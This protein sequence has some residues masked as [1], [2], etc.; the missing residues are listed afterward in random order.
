LKKVKIDFNNMKPLKQ[1][2]AVFCISLIMILVVFMPFVIMDKGSFTY[3]GDYNCQ[4]MAFYLEANESIRNGE[5]MW[6]FNTDL[7]ANFIGSY[8]FY[9]IGSPFFWLTLLLPLNWVSASIPF[10]ICIKTAVAAT[11]SF[12]FLKRVVKNKNYAFIDCLLYAFSGFCFYNVFFN[13][14]HDIIALF[15]LMLIGVEKMLGEGKKGFMAV[16]V[17]LNAVTNYYFFVAEV[18]FT[19]IY[20]IVGLC[21]KRWE[22]LNL[23]R[24]FAFGLECIIGFLMA[25]FIVLPAVLTTLQIDRASTKL[26]GWNLL[27]YNETQ[28]PLQL[29]QG[30]FMPPEICSITNMLPE[31][32]GRW[33]SVNAYLPMFGMA[34][35]I[36][37]LGRRKKRSFFDYMVWIP[38]IMMFVPVLNSMFQLFSNNFY[39]RWLFTLV[40]M[41]SAATIKALEECTFKEWIYGIG[42][43]SAVALGLSVAIAL[44][45]DPE[46]GERGLCKET[47]LLWSQIAILVAGLILTLL[48]IYAIKTDKKHATAFATAF[49][50]AFCTLFGI[51]YIAVSKDRDT[52]DEH[53]SY[54]NKIVYGRWNMETE[55]NDGERIDTVNCQSNAP[56]YWNMP[57]PRAFHSIVPGSV[58]DFYDAIGQ[59]RDVKSD[60]DYKNYP[61]QSLLSVRYLFDGEPDNVHYGNFTYL[62]DDNGNAVY[63]YKYYIPM[64]FGYDYYITES[65]LT[66]IQENLRDDVMLAVMV[67]ADEQEELVSDTMTKSETDE[68]YKLIDLDANV[69]DRKND[70]CNEFSYGRNSFTADYDND[71]DSVVFFSIPYEAGWSA[72]VNGQ[73]AEIIKTNV[74]FMAVK[75]EAGDN[76][77]EFKYVTPGLKYGA[78]LA[79]ISL[80]G[81]IVYMCI[82]KEIK[83]KEK[84]ECYCENTT[85]V[86]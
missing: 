43:T 17:F 37:Y 26:T 32:G 14:F 51:Y 49:V 4:Q 24:F 38:V 50:M 53:D 13:H 9:L 79:G 21:T 29:I 15:P 12:G 60:F 64:G 81:L 69:S 78:I 82:G 36:T 46:T 45:K 47:S 75:T 74:G 71:S 42:K 41:M 57:S 68:V 40:L 63:E 61:L 27:T 55:L 23:K 19:V 83:G 76:H 67:I 30:L 58:F 2:L 33:S 16:A 72:T 85:N 65:Q 39:T 84:E 44:I 73:D 6:N 56:L 35:T 70:C 10:L 18:V 3:I 54:V 62:N 8:A 86:V 20:F 7:G 34:G 11:T 1:Y 48:A 5:L 28:R 59:K 66:D 22:K 31:A 80:V 77:I 25:A 52:I